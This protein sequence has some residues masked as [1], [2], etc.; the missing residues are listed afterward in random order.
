[1][2]L[3]LCALTLALLAATSAEAACVDL[4]NKLLMYA[5]KGP[6]VDIVDLNQTSVARIKLDCELVAGDWGKL[7]LPLHVCADADVPSPGGGQCKVIELTPLSG[8]APDGGD[9]ELVIRRNLS[10]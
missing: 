9:F 4:P 5:R 6:S 1:M 7:A 2:R 8:P 3:S 10:K